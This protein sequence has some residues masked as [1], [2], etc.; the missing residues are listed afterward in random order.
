MIMRIYESLKYRL[1]NE[2][3]QR[4]YSMTEIF[5]KSVFFFRR[6][7]HAAIENLKYFLILPYARLKY[8]GNSIYLVAER[9][10]DARDNG[11]HFFKYLRERHP[12][13]EA[14]YVITSGSADYCKVAA[15]GKTVEYR[16]FQHYC[17]FAAAK[18]KISTH[19]MGYSPDMLH[20]INVNRRH[21]IPGKQIFLQHGV[22]KDDLIGLYQQQTRAD[23]FIC[24]AYPEY[25]YVKST[26]NYRNNE[27]KYTG[28]A[29][30]DNLYNNQVKNQILVMPT[31]RQYL[32]E[33]DAEGRNHSDYFKLWNKLLNDERIVHA[34]RQN[35]MK[36]IFYPHY[37]MQPY[38]SCFSSAAS[39]VEIADFAHYDVQMLLKESKLLITDFSSVFFDFA[40]MRK[41]CIYFQFD[42]D[43]FYSTHYK[44]GYFNYNDMGF[45]EVE[46]EYEGLIA[47]LLKY[48]ENGCIMDALYEERAKQFF[49]LHDGNN[50]ERIMEEIEKLK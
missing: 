12:E 22:I 5:R 47:T 8:R 16:S 24:G 21:R 39:E 7:L 15:L 32:K 36:L 13:R 25:E 23:I 19:I 18:Y 50:C 44:K 43:K 45:G 41:P 40:Y 48:I 11:Y 27:V 17:L 33:L 38:I 34:L 14:Y 20:Y 42:R 37:E 31:W 1:W 10:T 46:T 30:Y 6:K 2:N 29:R 4:Y 28:L 49:L 9:G 3:G 26:F 35:G